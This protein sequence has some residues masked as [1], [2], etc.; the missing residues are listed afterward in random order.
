MWTF[1]QGIISDLFPGV[2]LPKS[3]YELLLQALEDNIAKL[4]LQPVPWFIGKIVQVPILC[5]PN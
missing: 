2:V 4:K 1:L 3:D 5:S